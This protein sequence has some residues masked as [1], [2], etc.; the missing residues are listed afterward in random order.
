MSHLIIE[1][2]MRPFSLNHSKRPITLPGGGMRMVSTGKAK[3]QKREL[4]GWLLRH[5]R[6]LK[7]MGQ[8]F[9]PVNHFWRIKYIW[10]YKLDEYFTKKGTLS[11]GTIDLD[12]GV[13]GFQDTLFGV[14][15]CKDSGVADISVLKAPAHETKCV[16]HISFHPWSELIP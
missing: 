2:P 13:K 15:G 6:Q 1:I 12:N 16:I 10:L 3:D 7:E 9:D 14:I 5:N 8:T 11:E 4:E